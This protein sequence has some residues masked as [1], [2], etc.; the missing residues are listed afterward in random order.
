ME[1]QDETFDAKVKV[2]QENV[3]HHVEEEQDELFPKV[4]KLIDEETLEAIGEAMEE[5]QDELISEGNPRDAVPGET[6]AAA[7]I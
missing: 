6:D 7:P 2:L 1:P 4:E 5:T 3:E